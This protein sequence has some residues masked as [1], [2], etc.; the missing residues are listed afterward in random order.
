MLFLK[1]VF[2]A[3]LLPGTVTGLLPYLIVGPAAA[4]FNAPWRS[5]Q[6][7]GL[8]LVVIGSA[9]LLW[10]IVDFAVH[11]RGTLAPVD[12]PK[13]LV[14]RGPYR[15]VRNPMYLGVLT[16]LLGETVFFRSISLLGYAILA[17]AVFVVVIL[18]YEEPV[19]RA[20]FGESYARYVRAVRRWIPGRP[21]RG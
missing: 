12:P 8:L 6:Y 3:L 20:Q 5:S 1:S 19:L 9:V 2:F 15:Y 13:E 10:S 4:L 16:V 7:L 21:Y 17:W 14:V 11:G 18:A